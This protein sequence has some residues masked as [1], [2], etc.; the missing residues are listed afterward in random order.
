MQL[1]QQSALERAEQ[2]SEL[3]VCCVVTVVYSEPVLGAEVQ[4]RQYLQRQVVHSVVVR[5]RPRSPMYF[6]ILRIMVAKISRKM[7]RKKEHW[8]SLG[9]TFEVT[10]TGVVSDVIVLILPAY[11]RHGSQFSEN[12]TR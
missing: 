8:L 11:R 10:A 1:S 7:D 12:K 5:R 3:S 6:E 2:P 4:T 9:S